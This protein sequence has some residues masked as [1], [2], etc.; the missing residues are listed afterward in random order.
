[1]DTIDKIATVSLPASMGMS[2]FYKFLR[3]RSLKYR[4][5]V[6]ETNI[7][8]RIAEVDAR[9]TRRLDDLYKLV[10]NSKI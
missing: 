4:L 9:T 1:M 7:L 3:K 8:N 10:V 2:A 5:N 6:F